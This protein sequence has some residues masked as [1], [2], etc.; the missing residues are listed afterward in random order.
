MAYFTSEQ[1]VPR[2]VFGLEGPA[3]VYVKSKVLPTGFSLATALLQQWHCRA[4]LGLLP[5]S[6]ACQL[7]GLDPGRELRQGRMLPMSI[8]QGPNMLE[9]LP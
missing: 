4:A 9:D 2:W 6:V 7:A 5:A 1:P 8:A 3:V